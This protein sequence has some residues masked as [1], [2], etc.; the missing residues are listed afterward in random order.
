LGRRDSG[1]RLDELRHLRIGERKVPMPPAA[2]DGEQSGVDE[3]SQVVA[4]GRRRDARL[5]SKDACG[6]R[7][8]VGQREQNLRARRLGEQRAHG[9]DVRVSSGVDIVAHAHDRNR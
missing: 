4:R 6:E 5:G 2:D 7:S 9:R 8:A 1:D 3:P